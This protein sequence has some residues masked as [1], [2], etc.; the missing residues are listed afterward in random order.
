MKLVEFCCLVIITNLFFSCVEERPDRKP[1]TIAQLDSLA[2]EGIYAYAIS[3]SEALPKFIIAGQ[4][5]ESKKQFEKA[6]DMFL[7]AAFLFEEK[8]MKMDSASI[9]ALRSLDNYLLGSDTMKIANLYKYY[10]YLV[11]M[12]G[13]LRKGKIN[14]EE[15]KEIYLRRDYDEG[16]AVCNFNLARLAIKERSF[17]EADSLLTKARQI[18]E[19]N[20][21]AGRL[22]LI[23]SLKMIVDRR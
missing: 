5:Y 9:Y 18:W 16:I 12:T 17:A 6:G 15:A 20:E 7:N 8:I 4:G 1:L 23:D 10:G 13:D 14:I 3:P 11:G 21:D 19:V 2:T 22:F